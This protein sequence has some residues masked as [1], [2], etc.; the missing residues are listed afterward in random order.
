PT[1]LGSDNKPRS[2]TTQQP[3]LAT[4]T[5]RGLHTLDSSR[6]ATPR[7]RAARPAARTPPASSE[8]RGGRWRVAVLSRRHPLLPPRAANFK[9]LG[10]GY[11]VCDLGFKT[12]S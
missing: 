1:E 5:S 12:L 10:E 9:C 11:F 4:A 8:F 6:G 3:S 7:S 2:Y